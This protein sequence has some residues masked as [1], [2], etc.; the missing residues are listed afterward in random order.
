MGIEYGVY[1]LAEIWQ[2]LYGT[3]PTDASS[4]A[5]IRTFAE[6]MGFVPAS[7]TLNYYYCPSDWFRS[8]SRE[9]VSS[10]TTPS[11]ASSAWS[12]YTNAGNAVNQLG[13]ATQGLTKVNSVSTG[14]FRTP[15]VSSPSGYTYKPAALLKMPLPSVAVAVAPL[16]GVAIGANMYAENPELW[17]KLSRAL[18]P[19]AYPD[20]SGQS[21]DISKGLM[22]VWTEVGEAAGE[23]LSC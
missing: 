2:N 3:F 7:K 15:N 19:W 10:L 18:L 8:V 14:Y 4:L 22:P 11:S 5:S 23:F 20:S 6:Q 9:A 16:A 1:T 13:A 21:V 17:T 12:A